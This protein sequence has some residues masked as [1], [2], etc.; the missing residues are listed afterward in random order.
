MFH[1]RSIDRLL[2]D[3]ALA[4]DT[5]LVLVSTVKSLGRGAPSLPRASAAASCAREAPWEF[6]A[7]F[8]NYLNAV[9]VQGIT[10]K[11]VFKVN[12]LVILYVF[13]LPLV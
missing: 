8:F 5:L 9:Q 4:Y 10:G 7:T 1:F 12:R 6:G 11:V 2:L 3:S 13:M